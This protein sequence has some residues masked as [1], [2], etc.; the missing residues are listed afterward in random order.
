VVESKNF[1]LNIKKRYRE[2]VYGLCDTDLLRKVADFFL[3]NDLI[4]KNVIERCDLRGR[5][6]GRWLNLKK[7]V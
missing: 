4:L 6:L 5:D 3:K 2:M 7:M 1:G